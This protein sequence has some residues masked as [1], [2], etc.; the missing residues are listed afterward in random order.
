MGFWEFF[1]IL[2]PLAIGLLVT[3]AFAVIAL[4]PADFRLGRRLS[5]AAGFLGICLIVGWAY[6]TDIG[7]W[8]RIP[9]I[10]ILGGTVAVFL[11]E[12]LRWITNREAAVEITAPSVELM[13][14]IKA[15][16]DFLGRKDENELRNEFDFPNMLEYN[17]RLQKREL[18]RPMVSKE[19]SD[20]IDN[21]TDSR[22][23][24]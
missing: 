18:A 22:I 21:F 11:S 23:C 4:T 19:V 9:I 10:L 13:A 5:R 15:I 1:F 24:E 3:V 6:K 8:I 12:G 2:V 16:D 17:I 7:P 20:D 14:D